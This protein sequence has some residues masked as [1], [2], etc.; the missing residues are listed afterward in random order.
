MF[1]RHHLSCP[2]HPA[3]NLIIHK[4][5]SKLLGQF[6]KPPMKFWRRHDIAAFTLDRFNKDGRHLLR[7]KTPFEE[8]FTNPL[9]TGSTTTGILLMMIRTAVTIG[10][11]NMSDPRDKR[12]EPLFMNHFA[13]R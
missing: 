1:N 9:N 4:E 5:N 12:G 2:S 10:I 3:L 7:R 8:I 6:I 13:G 11:R